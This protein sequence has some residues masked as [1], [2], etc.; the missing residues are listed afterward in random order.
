MKVRIPVRFPSHEP[1]AMIAVKEL[2]SRAYSLGAKDPEHFLFPKNLSRI[3]NVNGEKEDKRGY[4]PT[5]HQKDWG[6]AWNSLRSKAGFPGLRFHD[7]RHTFI[8][9]LVERGVPFPVIQAM[10]GHIGPRM[11][12]YYKHLASGVARKA[13]E[14]LDSEPIMAEKKDSTD[15][16][17][18][19]RN[20]PAPDTA[21]WN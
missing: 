3:Q 8:T 7:L 4:D 6:T 18:E 14:L 12:Q 16:G 2:L 10:V 5:Q 19:E 13:V 21:V 15:W 20:M 1:A 17:W 9:H 11:V